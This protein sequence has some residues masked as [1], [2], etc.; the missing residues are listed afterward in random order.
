[1]SLSYFHWSLGGGEHC[2]SCVPGIRLCADRV[3]QVSIQ[4]LPHQQARLYYRELQQIRYYQKDYNLLTA[5]NQ[6][7][8]FE[9][10]FPVVWADAKSL[11]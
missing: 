7:H 8:T 10:A 4:R 1:M 5:A 9:K 6:L 11:P 2:H 3:N